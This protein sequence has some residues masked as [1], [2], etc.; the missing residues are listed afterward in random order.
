MTTLSIHLPD[1]LKA[2]L[3]KRA[4]ESGHASVEAYVEE[5]LR[6]EA[7][8]IDHGAPAGQHVSSRQDLEALIRDGANSPAREMT[9]ADWD[10]MRRRMIDR[11]RQQ[12]AG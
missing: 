7:T 5:L 4:A 12:K 2:A 1:E 6:D 9:P 10:D 3:A 8:Q 11:N